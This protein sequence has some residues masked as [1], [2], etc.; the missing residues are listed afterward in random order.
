MKRF[1]V[2]FR[3]V[4]LV[5]APV[6]VSAL[7]DETSG[8][9]LAGHRP[10]GH[11]LRHLEKCLS[12]LDLPSDQQTAIQSI[13]SNGEATLQA[14]AATMKSD[15]QKLRTDIANNADKSV[16]GQ[17]LLNQNADMTKLQTDRQAIRDQI[18]AK[19]SPS[20]QSAFNA[21]AQAG[22]GEGWGSGSKGSQQ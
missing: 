14:D 1:L 13:F 22:R 10:G 9:G 5:I 6:A 8:P 4:T 16:L 17:D 15:H 19:L 2:L 7:A 20:Q 3:V 21:C 12:T 18:L 11:G